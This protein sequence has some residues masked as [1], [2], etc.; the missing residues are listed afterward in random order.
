MVAF[1]IP[2]GEGNS[3]ADLIPTVASRTFTLERGNDYVVTFN[4][5]NIDDPGVLYLY[6]SA[7]TVLL[8]MNQGGSYGLSTPGGTGF[9]FKGT[10]GARNA[11]VI[12]PTITY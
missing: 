3:V 12:N 4:P 11:S 6:D 9:Y 2:I 10:K 8:T 5:V 1:P 7:N